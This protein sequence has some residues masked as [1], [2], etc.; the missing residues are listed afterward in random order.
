MGLDIMHTLLN[1]C[2]KKNESH[3]QIIRDKF[4]NQK[5][6]NSTSELASRLVAWRTLRRKLEDMGEGPTE[7]AQMGSL[8]KVVAKLEEVKAAKNAAQ[9]IK[10]SPLSVYE[11]LVMLDNMAAD[12]EQEAE[13]PNAD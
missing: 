3:A 12:A 13:K 8:L 9:V 7:S 1:R 4:N 11:M 10:D 6:T 5:P 2:M